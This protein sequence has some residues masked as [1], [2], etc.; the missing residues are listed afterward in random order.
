MPESA[1]I[2]LNLGSPEPSERLTGLADRLC[3]LL[4]RRGRPL[5]V[6]QIVQQVIRVKGAP[7]RLQR[8]LVA[9]IVDT[10]ERLG[11]RARD[12]VGFA[13]TQLEYRDP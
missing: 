12:L 7:E 1:T 5:E 11:W 6:G 8:L 4:E 9:E 10:D 3:A 2:P 13:D